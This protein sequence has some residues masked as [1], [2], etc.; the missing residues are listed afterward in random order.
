MSDYNKWIKAHQKIRQA[1]EAL[2]SEY[3]EADQKLLGELREIE[4]V[5]LGE[6]NSKFGTTGPASCSGLSGTFYRVEDVIPHVNDWDLLYRWIAANNAF[7]ALERRVTR[8]FVKEYMENHKDAH[9]GSKL[10]PGV[11]VI[12]KHDVRVRRAK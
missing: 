3:E 8:K 7:E 5:M 4:S 12:R 11:S 6:L 1:R 2:K 9:G 10:P